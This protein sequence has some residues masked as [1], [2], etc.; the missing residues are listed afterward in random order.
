MADAGIAATPKHFPGLGRVTAN[1]DTGTDVTDSAT[2]R[3]DA[4]VGPF[5]DAVH[6]GAPW[7]MLSNAYYPAID[8]ANYAV[9]SP[10][11]IQ[12]ML[13]GDLGFRG[14]A[15]SDDVCDAAQLS[16]FSLEHRGANFLAAGGTLVL[17]TDQ[18]LVPRVWQGIVDRAK[19]DPSFARTVDAAALA[20]LDAKDAAG[21]LPR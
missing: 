1:T 20:V 8:S 21:L 2:T 6:A 13:R 7:A 19:S 3:T 12:G 4:Y 16:G 5:G 17:C 15:V 18:G 9:F 14:I 11:V 10:T